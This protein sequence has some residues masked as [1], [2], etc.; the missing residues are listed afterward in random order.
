MAIFFTIVLAL[1][2]V[3]MVSLLGVKQW[4]LQT[5]NLLW[6]R[7]RPRV[8]DFF[9]TFLFWVERVLPALAH[10]WA[11]RAIAAANAWVHRTVAQ[12]VL[13]AEHWLERV[14]HTLRHTTDAKRVESRGVAS[15]FLQEVAEHKKKLIRRSKK[16]P[17]E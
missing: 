1:S 3:G 10:A 17:K 8:G 11:R 4:E 9:H 13:F 14:L 16:L 7:M 12:G 6:V 2:I 15:V 5:N